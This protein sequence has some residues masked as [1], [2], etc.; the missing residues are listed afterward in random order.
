MSDGQSISGFGGKASGEMN[1]C[2]G[3]GLAAD[4]VGNGLRLGRSIPT[5]KIAVSEKRGFCPFHP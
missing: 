4:S 5:W 3:S 2:R 1:E